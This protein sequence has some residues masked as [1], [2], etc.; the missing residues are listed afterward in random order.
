MNSTPD[1]NTSAPAAEATRAKLTFM[2]RTEQKPYIETEALTGAK[3]PRYHAEMEVREVDIRDGR[4]MAQELSLDRNGFL[5][6]DHATQARDLYDDTE[7][8]AV[9][10]PEAETLIR[11]ITGASRVVVFDHTRRTDAAERTGIRGPARRVHNDY[12]EQSGP[13]RVREVLSEEKA[14]ALAGM[15]FTQINLWRPIRGPVLRSPI[16]VLDSTSL[17]P[18][19]LIATDMLYPGRVGEI[20]HLA[21]NPEQ[22]WFYFPEM[23]RDEAL[24]I[25][26]YDSRRNGRA[27]FTPHTAF[28]HPATAADAPPRESIELRTLAFFEE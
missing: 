15:P 27:R 23:R 8:K 10:Y 7:V 26:G 14:E 6:L 16:A 28:D 19:D 18:E 17:D 21:Y 13:Q 1:R 20:Y 3:E 11:S 5:L 9:Y 12:T 22:H 24:L 25:K 2:A 4:P